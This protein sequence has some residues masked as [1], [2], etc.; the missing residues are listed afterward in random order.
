MFLPRAKKQ[1]MQNK[2]LDLGEKPMMKAQIKTTRHVE[3]RRTEDAAAVLSS[4]NTTTTP[5]NFQRFGV[6]TQAVLVG[7]R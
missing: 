5:A 1:A 3:P 7:G 4:G 2:R 6:V